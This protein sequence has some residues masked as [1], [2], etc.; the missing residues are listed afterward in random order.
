MVRINTALVLKLRFEAG[1]KTCIQ[2]RTGGHPVSA[3]F[4]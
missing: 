4:S 1:T 3:D 2:S